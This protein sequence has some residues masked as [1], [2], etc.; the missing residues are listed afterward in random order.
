MKSRE[1]IHT[2]ETQEMG[3]VTLHPK[4]KLQSARNRE[5][6]NSMCGGCEANGNIKG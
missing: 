2:K 3:Q 1:H 5:G 4:E 6:G